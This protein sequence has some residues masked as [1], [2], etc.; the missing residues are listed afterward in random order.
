MTA[1]IS[2]RDVR[3]VKI[4]CPLQRNVRAALS[5]GRRKDAASAPK[6]TRPAGA[7]RAAFRLAAVRYLLA[8]TM[9]DARRDRALRDHNTE[10]AQS[11]VIRVIGTSLFVK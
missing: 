10:P 6:Q 1:L 7:E 2:A 5:Q 8:T 4:A 11:R 3:A 9:G